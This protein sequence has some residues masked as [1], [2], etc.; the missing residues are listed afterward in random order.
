MFFLKVKQF[1]LQESI[2]FLK[3]GLVF[4][5]TCDL[6]GQISDSFEGIFKF[7]QNLA[8]ISPKLLNLSIFFFVKGVTEE[9]GLFIRTGGLKRAS[10]LYIG[11]VFVFSQNIVLK[12]ICLFAT[13]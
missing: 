1:V 3:F 11:K 12:A 13:E 2:L 7:V 6:A 4:F 10:H 8:V 5:E 9:H